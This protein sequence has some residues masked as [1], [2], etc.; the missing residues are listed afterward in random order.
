VAIRSSRSCLAALI[1]LQATLASAATIGLRWA[2]QPNDPNLHTA[3]GGTVNIV[4]DFVPG[5]PAIS[6]ILFGFAWDEPSV[7]MTGSSAALAGLHDTSVYLPIGPLGGAA[8]VAA[9]LNPENDFVPNGEQGLVV[10]TFDLTLTS[11][12]IGETAEVA[13]A[14]L[15]APNGVYSGASPMTWDNRYNTAYSGFI[16]F[17]DYGSPGWADEKGKG[18]YVLPNP[19]LITRIV[20]EPANTALLLLGG[21]ALWRRPR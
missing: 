13:I 18:Q 21:L 12:V 8:Y 7:E 17:G 2:S 20:P 9:S 11:L 3:T 10:G 1:G 16:A 14:I 6:G 4:M 5:D 15:H 19:L